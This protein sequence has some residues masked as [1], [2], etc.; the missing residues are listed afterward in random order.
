M[1]P[2]NIQKALAQIGDNYHLTGIRHPLRAKA[3]SSV[4]RQTKKAKRRTCQ[5]TFHTFLFHAYI[6]LSARTA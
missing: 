4:R 2:L 6:T 1:C 3:K 5:R